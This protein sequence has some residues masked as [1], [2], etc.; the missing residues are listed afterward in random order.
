[1]LDVIEELTLTALVSESK[2]Y[3]RYDLSHDEKI[4]VKA[5]KGKVNS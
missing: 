3:V 2:N 4:T 5:W 1:M